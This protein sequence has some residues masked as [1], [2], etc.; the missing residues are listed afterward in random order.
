[1]V[2]IIEGRLLL[3]MMIQHA[4]RRHVAMHNELGVPMVVTL[5]DVLGRGHRQQ[6]HSQTQHARDNPRR[7]HAT[8]RIRPWAARANG[9]RHLFEVASCPLT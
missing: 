1:M 3:A 9:V 5:V 2:V 6:A 4:V 8:N 7:P